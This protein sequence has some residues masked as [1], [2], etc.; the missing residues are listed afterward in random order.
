[1]LLQ[2]NMK[3][4]QLISLFNLGP[5]TLKLADHAD[6]LH[7]GYRPAGGNGRGG[8]SSGLKRGDWFKLIDQLR[9]IDNPAV[10]RRPSK[11]AIPARRGD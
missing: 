3:P 4:H 7:I 6:H 10:G 2:G 5:P 11:Y 9:K 8:L 1:M